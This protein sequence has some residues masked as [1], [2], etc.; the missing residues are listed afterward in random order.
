MLWS[1]YCISR[2][3]SL[4]SSLVPCTH[5]TQLIRHFCGKNVANHFHKYSYLCIS[6]IR[7]YIRLRLQYLYARRR[8]RRWHWLISPSEVGGERAP[9]ESSKLVSVYWG[10]GGRG[11]GR[12]W[13]RDAFIRPDVHQ[14]LSLEMFSMP[15]FIEHSR[16]KSNCAA[17]T[18]FEHYRTTHLY[19]QN[20]SGFLK[21]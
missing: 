8:W 17:G 18:Y 2:E 7:I 13:D 11:G 10:G 3:F 4:S 21:K 9:S 19:R 6:H 16:V 12:G 14:R 20:C 15:A 1:F 5:S